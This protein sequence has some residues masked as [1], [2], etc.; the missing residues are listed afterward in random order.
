MGDKILHK[1]SLTQGSVP[2][3]SSLEIGELAMNV[4]DGKIFMRRSGSGLDTTTALVSV[5]NTTTGSINVSGSIIV[6]GSTSLFGLTVISGSFP[7]GGESASFKI[8]GNTIH[9]GYT[10]FNPVSTGINNS[11][12]ASYIYVSGS[13]NDLYFTQNGDGFSNT[14]R[15]RWIEGNLYTGLLNGGIISSASSTTFNVSSGSGII[16]TMNGSLTTDPYPTIQYVKWNNL[17]NQTLTYRTTAIQTFIGID[18]NSNIIQQTSPWNDG[19]YN[20]SISLGTVIHQNLSTINATITYPNVAYGY[21]QR[22]YDFIKAFGPLRLSGLQVQTSSSLG[23]TVTSGTAWADGRNYQNDP[24]NPSYIIDSGT[25]VS[26]IFRYYAS[27]STFVQ[28]TNGG[29]GYTNIDPNNYNLNGTGVLSTVGGNYSIQRVF[30]YPNSATKGIVVY[31]GNATYPTIRDAIDNLNTEVF[32]EVANTQ[33]NAVYIGS[34]IIKGSSDFTSTSNYQIVPAGLFRSIGGSGG[35]GSIPTTRLTDLA[36]VT[37]ASPTDYQAFVYDSAL[38]KWKNASVISASIVGNATT[39][40][41]AISASTASYAPNYVLN[42]V[43]ASMLSP[44]V[45]TSI[46]SSMT[47]LSSSYAQTASYQYPIAVTGS[48]LYSV[49]PSTSN[50]NGNSSIFLGS[51]AGNGAINSNY[52][53]FLGLQSGQGATSADESIFIGPLNGLG[54]AKANGSVFIGSGAGQYATSAS[55]S[56]LIG[57]YAGST[58]SDSLLSI[59][60]NNIILGNNITLPSKA[61]NSIN[62]GAIIFAT[63]S[64]SLLGAGNLYSGSVMG[65]VGIN[66][67][68]PQYNFDV[69]GSGNYSNGLTVT[70][71]VIATSFTGSLQ[72]TS[73]WSN[74]T[75]T[76]SYITTAQTASYYGGSVTSASY[77][78]TASS[79]DNFLIRQS[80][81]ASNALINGTITAQ[82]L[83]VQTITASVEY[84]SGS[85]IFGSLL[86]NTHQF[87]GSVNI[88]GSLT[89][90]GSS[91]ATLSSSLS[92]VSSSYTTTSASNSTRLTNLEATASTS[93]VVSSSYSSMS[94]SVSTRLSIIEGKYLTTG[95]NIISGSQTI[96]GSVIV[97]GSINVTQGVTGSIFG[98]SSFSTNAATASYVLQAVSASFAST[99]SYVNTL[100]QNLI[101]SGSLTVGTSSLGAS[102]NTL[103]LGARDVGG[104]GGQ[105]G[106]NAPGGTYTSA[107][108]LDNYQNL[109]RLL[110]GTNAGSDAVVT[111]WNMHSKQV[112]FPAYNSTTAFTATTLVGLLGFDASGNIL[113]TT[114]SSGGGGGGVSITNNTDNYILTAT[115]VANSING[116]SNLQFNGSTLSVV[117][118]VT[119]TSI[120]SSGAVIAQANGAMYFRGGDDAELWDV[121]LVNTVGVYGQQTQTEGSIKLGSSGSRLYGSGSNLGINTVIPNSASLHVSGNIFA[122]SFTGSLLGTA[123]WTNNA[124]TSSYILQAVSASYAAT[125]SYAPSY[126]LNSTTASMLSPYTLNSATSSG[127]V[128]SS[129]YAQTSS[130]AYKVSGSMTGSLLGTSSYALNGG[131]TQ[132]V[133]G[134]NVTISPTNGLG[135][136]TI[137]SSGGGAS[138]PYT[139]SA[140]ITGSL[141]VTGSITSTI[142]FSGSHFGTSSW[143]NN[144]VSASYAATSSYSNGFTINAD[145]FVFTG[146]MY[147]SGSTY[148]TG[149]INV[150]GGVTGSLLGTASYAL[151]A[152]YAMNGGGSSTITVADEGTAQGTA[153]FL[154]FI[155]TGVTA[156]VSAGTGS[157]TISGGGGGLAMK[158]GTASIAAFTGNPKK[159]TV[160]FSSAFGSANYAVT[161]TGEDARSWTIESKVAGSFVI[162]SNS[163]TSVSGITYWH[164]IAYGES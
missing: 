136:V 25:A 63:G 55:Y 54:A 20:T 33:Q 3:T 75:I 16:V 6:T 28:D 86:T 82:T 4:N 56:T 150:R 38:L 77:A 159:A 23:L 11:V 29:V 163:N 60:T 42:S 158:S 103:T 104:E 30:W 7:L 59:G 84:S 117:G 125:S 12:S 108:M 119:A 92:S 90:N 154:N 94:G 68:N 46:T 62:I 93:I 81:T 78:A 35:G 121:N 17:T 71:S 66:I 149:S 65:K 99:A 151:T 31:Y 130:L 126:V 109:T 41:L 57:Y 26:K 105:L 45:L 21:K 148:Q 157:I 88:T 67:S 50:F 155:G 44:Y 145:V 132:I 14:T 97:T 27:A 85:N 116:E 135:A 39:A 114:T 140:V 72:G 53:I 101:I 137:N 142:G 58:T 8:H 106:L 83:V 52:S 76:A 153:T 102:E 80:I 87:T 95:S 111:Q 37:I 47:V 110:R 138:F 5:N 69:S 96:T 107:S 129:S 118:N 115:G 144:V 22:T 18:S 146:S 61:R 113:T 100:N 164:A 112:S 120:T 127:T 79:A 74:N 24:S 32:Y 161:V 147:I 48:T 128:L 131:V 40:T 123:S 156:T 51:N 43:T 70:G 2:L 91:Y 134:T 1:R 89:V 139:G 122:T 143:A 9:E 152:S 19:Q 133:A 124:V 162:N 13:T 141:I 10:R 36:D 15:L 49:N 160:T 34:V 64:Y 98:T 73:S